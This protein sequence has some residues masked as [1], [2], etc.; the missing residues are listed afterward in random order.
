MTVY[1]GS[2]KMRGGWAPQPP[3]TTLIN[4]TSMQKKNS[5]FRRDFSPM[6]PVEGG[7]KGFYCFENWWQGNKVFPIHV[8]DVN[9]RNEFVQ[10]WRNLNEGKRRHPTVRGKPAYAIYDDGIMRGYIDARKN[11]YVK[12][13]YDLMIST[14]AFKKCKE[15]VDSGKNVAVYDFDGPRDR[16]GKKVCLEV[17]LDMLKDKVNDEKFP[18]G[19]GYVI[20]AALKGYA[21]SDYC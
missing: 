6:S 20:A 18:F 9:K 11:I 7:Y 19:H 12:Q 15:M 1:I 13:Y 8:D 10:W 17:T 2:M 3:N 4:A 16:L 14:E 5:I 21:P